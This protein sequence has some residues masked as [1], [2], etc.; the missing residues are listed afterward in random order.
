MTRKTVTKGIKTTAIF[1]KAVT[2]SKKKN[3]QEKKQ[4][5]KPQFKDPKS[6]LCF[7]YR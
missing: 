6:F 7:A 2:K 5:A 3:K 1:E 4:A